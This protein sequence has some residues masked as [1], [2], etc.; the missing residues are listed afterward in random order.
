M[1]AVLETIGLKAKAKVASEIVTPAMVRAANH[2]AT[3]RGLCYQLQVS[4]TTHIMKG[5]DLVTLIAN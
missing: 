4:M 3:V 2:A 1:N 5:F